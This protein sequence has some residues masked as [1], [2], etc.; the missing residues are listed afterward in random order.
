VLL[1]KKGVVSSTSTVA[2]LAGCRQ[3]AGAHAASRGRTSVQALPRSRYS[4]LSIAASPSVMAP[5][6]EA[7]AAAHVP[8]NRRSTAG[9]ASPTNC[10]A[11]RLQVGSSGC[12]YGRL[13]NERSRWQAR[14]R[15]GAVSTGSQGENMRC[16][17][18]GRGGEPR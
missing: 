5:G 9:A 7:S 18:A 4:L 2:K 14:V 3:Q 6:G 16:A 8:A 10:P 17:S 1:P 13:T 11:A 15:L 12:S